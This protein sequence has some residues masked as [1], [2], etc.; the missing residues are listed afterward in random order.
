M[1]CAALALGLWADGGRPVPTSRSAVRRAAGVAVWPAAA[2]AGFLLFSRIVV[3]EWFV[4]SGFFVPENPAQGRPLRRRSPVWWGTQRLSSYAARSVAGGDGLLALAV[5]RISRSSRRAGAG[6]RV[7]RWPRPRC[8]G[9]AF[10][11]GHPFRIR[12]MVPL[13]AAEAVGVGVA[14]GLAAARPP[15]RLGRSWRSWSRCSSNPLSPRGADGRRSAVGSAQ[16]RRPA[17]GHRVACTRTTTGRRSWPAWDRSGTT[18]RTCPGE[19][20]ELRDFLHEGNGDIWLGALERPRPFVGW[21]LIEELC[22]RRRH[23]GQARAREPSMARRVHARGRGRG[24][25]A[26][27]SARPGYRSRTAPRRSP[28]V[29]A[30]G[31][32]DPEGDEVV[33]A[34][35]IDLRPAEPARLRRA[36]LRAVLVAD[37]AAEAEAADRNVDAAEDQRAGRRAAV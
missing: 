17:S 28:G 20:F 27:S 4:S 15:A 19:G 12:Y 16:R 21:I 5:R 35:E 31:T 34:A 1:T 30:F 2:I 29:G 26:V 32:V 36:R 23:A 9:L 8:P 33:Q 22:G 24:P 14:A 6:G 25:R 3:G 7:P 13:L 37:L 18:C 11:D 10:L